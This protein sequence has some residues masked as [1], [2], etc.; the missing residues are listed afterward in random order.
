MS[1]R[2]H[3]NEEQWVH[4]LNELAEQMDGLLN[5]VHPSAWPEICESRDM[6]ALQARFR[7]V[8]AQPTIFD[9]PQLALF[10]TDA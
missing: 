6:R 9:L 7:R 2:S 1:K 3:I 4:R 10:E 5:G 8:A